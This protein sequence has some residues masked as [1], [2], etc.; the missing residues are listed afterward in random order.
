MRSEMTI[1]APNQLASFAPKSEAL[2][3]EPSKSAIL[4]KLAPSYVRV[5][6]Q[7]I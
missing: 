7:A 4:L 2:H 5:N 1:A 6:A 3:E